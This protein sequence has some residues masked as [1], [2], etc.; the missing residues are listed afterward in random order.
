[1]SIDDIISAVRFCIDEEKSNGASFANA[2]SGDDTSM[3]NIIKN[4][5][6]DA[7]RWVCL[8]APAELLGG[9]DE[10]ITTG[11]GT[12]QDPTITTPVATGILVDEE[13]TPTAAY[14]NAA[15]IISLNDN[16]IKLARVR[17][18]GW[19]RAVK[20]PLSEDS[21]E[22]LQL[23]DTNGATATYD[24]PQAVII[25]AATKKME[26]WPWNPGD[27]EAEE[28]VDADE[29]SLTYVAS[30]DPVGIGTP[31]TKYAL[32]PL[33]KPAFI[34]YLAFLLLSAYNDPRAE[35]MLAIAQM[36]LGGVQ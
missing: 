28:P 13:P 30:V 4:K 24:R 34:Y 2:S 36:N 12:E 14:D 8:Y 6:G 3:N 17:V 20:V 19:H 5:I 21:E 25:D 11:S 22:Y 23:M 27:S 10:S 26:L 7:L 33:A 18:E 9:S 1:M 32:P 31:V 35:R 15:G 16:F 29:V